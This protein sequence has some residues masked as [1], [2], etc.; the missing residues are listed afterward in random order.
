MGAL[1]TA[2]W[3]WTPDRF[4]TRSTTSIFP[5]RLAFA[6]N[7]HYERMTRGE[8]FERVL[9][10]T[11][12]LPNRTEQDYIVALILGLPLVLSLRTRPDW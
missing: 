4:S 10:L 1:W 12:R 8:A 5:V 11:T 7:M 9:A 3:N 2:R 6:L